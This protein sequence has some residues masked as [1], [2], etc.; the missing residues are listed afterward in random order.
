MYIESTY[1]CFTAAILYSLIY[2]LLLLLSIII[3]TIYL[4]IY[5]YNY[6]VSAMYIYMCIVFIN[7]NIYS[8]M[9]FKF[10][11]VLP[12]LVNPTKT[13]LKPTKNH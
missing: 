7:Y 13:P 3:I 12:N 2:I 9:L 11:T 6:N 5:R 10:Q 4:Y 8:I 1:T